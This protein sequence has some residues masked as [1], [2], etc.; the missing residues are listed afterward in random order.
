MSML[1]HIGR[2]S[3]SGA[4]L[5]IVYNEVP[6]EPT[7]CLVID[8]D[9]LTDSLRNE[10]YDIIISQEA[11]AA[12][13]LSEILADKY[14]TDGKSYLQ[15]LHMNK[16]LYKIPT[17]E[18]IMEFG[19]QTISLAE[20]NAAIAKIHAGTAGMTEEEIDHGR[21]QR[22][23]QIEQAEH[24]AEMNK[25]KFLYM[26]AED[27]EQQLAL[28]KAEIDARRKE[29]SDIMSRYEPK[30][31]LEK[32]IKEPSVNV[33]NTTVEQPVKRGRGRPKVNKDV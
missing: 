15:A 13:N 32:E 22:K 4:R 12:P 11:Q 6:N 27:M 23:M 2:K 14:F 19:E 3:E 9:A 25:A 29:A 28:M 10:I 26:Q 21:N 8:L 18:V 33:L 1:K 20:L 7:N 16:K 5:A 17:I 31:K 30:K 24:E